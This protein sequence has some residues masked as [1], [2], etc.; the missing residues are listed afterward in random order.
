M[1]FIK[2]LL[3]FI[4]QISSD[5][6]YAW[7][8]ETKLNLLDLPERKP[9]SMQKYQRIPRII[10]QTHETSLF[11]WDLY[12]PTMQLISMNREYQYKFYTSEARLRTLMFY[13]GPNSDEVRAYLK[14]KTG[15]WQADLF[16]V[17][18]LCAEGGIY[19]DC[20]GSTIIPFSEFIPEDSSF[21]TFIDIRPYRIATGSM[22]ASTA[23]NPVIKRIKD[24]CVYRILTE[25]YG[26]NPLDCAGPQACG[27]ALL[28]LLEEKELETR[29]YAHNETNID[30]LG[31]R[32]LF[33]EFI[34]DAKDRPLI[35]R[36]PPAYLF[37]WN[38]LWNR[39]EIGWIL[40]RCFK[41]K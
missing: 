29:R 3:S 28:S 24:T 15:T 39:Y 5:L 23:K 25:N 7:C 8:V 19:M 12:I 18:I 21:A 31:K 11:S 26:Q 10:H 36:Q 9:S 37:N 32:R 27:E 38:R 4:Y 2:R 30:I 16:R 13:Y 33:G 41:R 35:K 1:N 22:L 17:C 6:F 20:K 34:C 14:I 40:K